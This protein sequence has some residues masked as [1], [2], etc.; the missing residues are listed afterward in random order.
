MYFRHVINFE[1]RVCKDYG[2][3][4]TNQLVQIVQ[5]VYGIIVDRNSQASAVSYSNT[6][7]PT[8]TTTISLSSCGPCAIAFG[9]DI[10]VWNTP[11]SGESGYTFNQ[12][13]AT[14]VIIIN[15]DTNVTSTTSKYNSV[16]F[17]SGGNVNYN[18]DGTAVATIPFA[19]VLS[20]SSFTSTTLM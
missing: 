13:I 16:T 8:T 19:G 6:T 2:C 10:I 11:Y 7:R 1:P 17:D 12:T 4:S 18:R 20:G 15:N 5:Y 9:P 3:N 14:Q